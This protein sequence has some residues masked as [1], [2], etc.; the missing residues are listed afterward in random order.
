MQMSAPEFTSS[1][2]F[3]TKIKLSTSI[4]EQTLKV[5]KTLQLLGRP[6][7]QDA[8]LSIVDVGLYMFLLK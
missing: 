8:L 7:T 2:G 1:H 5:I 4:R 3:Q 6:Q